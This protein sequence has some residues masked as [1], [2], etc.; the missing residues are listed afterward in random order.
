MIDKV[1]GFIGCGNMGKS[2]VEGIMKAKFVQGDHMFVSN[3]HPQKLEPLKNKYEF[4]LG[5]NKDVA[6]IADI[7]VLAIKPYLYPSIIME[8]KD[9]VKE[10]TIIV[11]IGTGIHIE[12]VYTM[13]E[14]ELKVVKAIPNTPAMVQEAMSAF[15]FGDLLDEDDK[16]FITELFETFGKTCEVTKSLLTS[17]SV[18]SGC[19]PAYVF[20]FIEALADGAV[21]Q[22]MPRSDA[23]TFGAQAVLGA[24]KMML[25][26]GLHP[27]ELKDMVC[28]PGGTAIEAVITLEESGFRGSILS[29]MKA[30]AIKSKAMS[31]K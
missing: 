15:V 13:F 23:Y 27:G 4:Q 26:T 2:M 11:D 29:A 20:M 3:L 21:L 24:A 7:I 22:G 9:I 28:S 6:R 14:R 10:D 30:C 31:E 18:V 12:D 8:I 17:V 16:E 19:S 1:I 25:E 5:S